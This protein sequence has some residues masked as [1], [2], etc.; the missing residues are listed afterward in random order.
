MFKKDKNG[1]ID[2]IKRSGFHTSDFSPEELDDEFQ[3]TYKDS[4]FLFRAEPKG[5][6]YKLAY[7]RFV[8]GYPVLYN[9]QSVN[10]DS[11]Y[12]IF[13]NWLNETLPKYLEEAS[14]PDLWAQIDREAAVVSDNMFAD[15]DTS[16]FSED[17]KAQCGY[18][19]KN[20]KGY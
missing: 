10:I 14:V 11:V 18:R 8:P 5:I 3:L 13:E 15:F 16:S 6:L 4:P 12:V 19:L 20:S 17:D 2:V 1:F 7:T 9:D